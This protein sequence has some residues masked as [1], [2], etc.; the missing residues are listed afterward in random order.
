M[1]KKLIFRFA[2]WFLNRGRVLTNPYYDPPTAQE[3][4]SIQLDTFDVAVE[5]ILKHEGGYVNDP[6]DNGGETNFG[7]SKRAYPHLDIRNL[8]REQAIAIYKR[9]YWDKCR[10]DEMPSGLALSVFD[11]AV[12]AG[13]NRAIR[14]LQYVLGVAVDG[15]IGSKT[16]E[17][18]SKSNDTDIY[19]YANQRLEFYQS[20][21]TWP[22]FGRGWTRRTEETLAEALKL[23]EDDTRS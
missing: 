1:I 12:N 2:R 23:Y 19:E 9:D 3:M 11:M 7:I 4:F 14:I 22:T 20:L 5:L 16:L 17:A 21:K 6:R 8:T 13:N 10:C 15:I 18:A